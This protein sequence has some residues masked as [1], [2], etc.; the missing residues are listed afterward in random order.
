MHS[1]LFTQREGKNGS[2]TATT[3]KKGKINKKCIACV[4]EEKEEAMKQRFSM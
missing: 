4:T 3:K 2:S 1:H